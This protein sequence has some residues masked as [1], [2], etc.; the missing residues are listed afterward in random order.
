[1]YIVETWII[2]IRN[3]I[4]VMMGLRAALVYIHVLATYYYMAFYSPVG[5]YYTCMYI[6]VQEY[7]YLVL[8]TTQLH[9]YFILYITHVHV[10]QF[11]YSMGAVSTCTLYSV[12]FALSKLL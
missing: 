11:Q 4:H 7:M 10:Y 8:Y 2:N 6:A 3:H 9:L 1:M 12:T 5:N